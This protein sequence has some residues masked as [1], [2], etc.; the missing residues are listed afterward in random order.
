MPAYDFLCS[1]CRHEWTRRVPIARR[2]TQLCPRCSRSASRKLA[3]PMVMTQSAQVP[4]VSKGGIDTSKLPV[5]GPDGK[6][7]SADGKKVLK[8]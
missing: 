5:V 2:D 3:A 6:L 4:R 8:E 1:S 7:Y